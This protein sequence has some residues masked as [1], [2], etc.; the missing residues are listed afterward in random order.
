MLSNGARYDGH[1]N[2]LMLICGWR[3]AYLDSFSLAVQS[4]IQFT[5][6]LISASG[7]VYKHAGGFILAAAAVAQKVARTF[8]HTRSSVYS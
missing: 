8:L 7:S 4:D 1:V 3:A 5:H 2:M 6:G